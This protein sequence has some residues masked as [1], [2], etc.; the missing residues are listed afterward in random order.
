VAAV[1][2]NDGSVQ[3]SEVGSI[4]VTFSQAV[5]LGANAFTLSR[6]GGGGNVGVDVGTPALDAQGRT[7]VTLTFDNSNPAVIDPTSPNNGGAPSL[8]DGR[9][10]L[11]IADA[12]V[13]GLGGAALDG[14]GDGI[15]GGAYVS[16]DDT[17]GSGTG[18]HLGLYRLFGDTDGNGTVDLTDLN[19]LRSAFNSFSGQTTYV[20]FLDA[21]N[22][23]TIDLADLS[24]FRNRFNAF[25]FP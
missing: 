3:R 14:D 18:Y 8:A 20:A 17:A 11:S 12:A 22:D 15:A 9:Y 4:T 13:T 5:T 1:Q 2:I 25:L 23:G 19:Q 24:E 7:V 10:R 6:L 21:N 16:P